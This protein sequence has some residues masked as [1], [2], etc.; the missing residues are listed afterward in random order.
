MKFIFY[1][2]AE[3]WTSYSQ[4]WLE[5]SDKFFWNDWKKRKKEKE[6]EKKNGFPNG[7]WFGNVNK[8]GL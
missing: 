1:Y 2:L 6:K 8:F 5:P 7:K 4:I 3:K